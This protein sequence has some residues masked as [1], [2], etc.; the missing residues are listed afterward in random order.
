MM[1]CFLKVDLVLV[2]EVRSVLL[3]GLNF[4]YECIDFLIENLGI[5]LV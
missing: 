5:K 3:V 2:V 1:I 4:L